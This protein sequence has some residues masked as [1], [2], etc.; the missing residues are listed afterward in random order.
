MKVLI[1]GGTRFVGPLLVFRLLAAGHQVT[2]L[3]RGTLADPFGAFG[4]RVER[5]VADRT[6]PAFAPLLAGRAFDAAVDFAAYTA[7]DALGAIAALSG[8]VGHYVFISTGQVYL[9]REGCP[10]PSRE[11]DYEG[12]VLPRPTEERDLP[13]WEYGAGKRACEDALVEA[14]D[15]A[16][17]PSTRIRIP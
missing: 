17:F 12:P 1:I 6:S 14:W 11:I 7:A 13:Q 3:N 9:V 16:R 8:R 4:G 5:L 10:R 15:K 2:V